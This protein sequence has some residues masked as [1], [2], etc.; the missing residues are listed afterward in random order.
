MKVLK[1]GGTSVGSSSSIKEVIDIIA[2]YKS[3]NI[4]VAMVASA[5]SG[6]TNKLLEMGKRASQNDETYLEILKDI[7]TLHFNTI[8]NCST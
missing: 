7:E 1:F 6:V 5:M 3:Q 2:G 8:K 4:H